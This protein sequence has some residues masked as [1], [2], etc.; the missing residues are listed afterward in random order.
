MSTYLTPYLTS[1]KGEA[2]LPFPPMPFHDAGVPNNLSHCVMCG[3]LLAP[4]S[5]RPPP[6][7][8][9]LPAQT[10][11]GCAAGTGSPHPL[12]YYPVDCDGCQLLCPP[13]RR[14]PTDLVVVAHLSVLCLAVVGVVGCP[15]L[16]ASMVLDSRCPSQPRC[17]PQYHFKVYTP[18]SLSSEPRR[19]ELS[20]MECHDGMCVSVCRGH[21][22]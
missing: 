3:S 19:P 1:C 6:P 5:P 9:S 7:S 2:T 13:L 21:V 16:V 12:A 15:T 14:S 22:L 4:A 11:C 17:V 20:C 18:R 10:T 8:L